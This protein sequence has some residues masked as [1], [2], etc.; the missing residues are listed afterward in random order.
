MMVGG[1]ICVCMSNGIARTLSFDCQHIYTCLDFFFRLSAYIYMFV[2][3]KL[4]MTWKFYNNK[5]E[6]NKKRSQIS[7]DEYTST[8][9]RLS[10]IVRYE[11]TA[12]HKLWWNLGATENQI[13]VQCLILLDRDVEARKHEEAQEIEV[14][15]PSYSRSLQTVWIGNNEQSVGQIQI[16]YSNPIAEILSSNHRD[17]APW[18]RA[19]IW[20]IQARRLCGL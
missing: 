19:G 3:R 5:P 11:W 17:Q 8:H 16:H 14:W 7:P 12:W 6:G 10:R 1:I 18:T 15:S 4:Y 13:Q 9:R 2:L 20:I